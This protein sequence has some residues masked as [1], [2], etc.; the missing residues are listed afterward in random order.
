M[1]DDTSPPA[2]DGAEP[3]APDDVGDT[4][5]EFV[6]QPDDDEALLQGGIGQARSGVNGHD[7]RAAR[8]IAATSR[9]LPPACT[10]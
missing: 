6:D 4:P 2:G 7:R 3:T 10:R 5:A 1:T 9:D 8:T